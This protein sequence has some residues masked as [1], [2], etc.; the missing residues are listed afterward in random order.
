MLSLAFRANGAVMSIISKCLQSV[1]ST[2]EQV[3]G[4]GKDRVDEVVI[5]SVRV[6]EKVRQEKWIVPDGPESASSRPW[7]PPY[8]SGSGLKI[9]SAELL[10]DSLLNAQGQLLAIPSITGHYSFFVAYLGVRRRQL[11]ALQREVGKIS[12]YQSGGAGGWRD[13]NGKAGEDILP[14]WSWSLATDNAESGIAIPGREGPA[15]V[16]IDWE[17]G[18]L[19]IDR[20]LGCSVG[21]VARLGKFILAPVMRGN[22]F[23]MLCRMEGDSSW[24][25][26]QSTFNAD[27]VAPQLRRKPEQLACFAVPVVDESRM[28]AYWPCRGGYV[29]VKEGDSSGEHVW[30]FRPWETDAYPATALI[31]LGPPFRKTGSRPGYWQ[32]CEDHDPSK[33][34][35]L[36][37]KIIKLDGDE[38]VDSDISEYGQ[39]VTTGSACFTWLY[40]HWSDLHQFNPNQGEHN[41]LRYPLLQFGEKG[42]TLVAKVRP[43]SGREDMGLFNEVFFN[44]FEKSSVYIRFVIEG[45]GTPE[46]A[47]YAEDVEGCDGVQGSLF[48]L[49]LAQLPEVSVFIYDDRIHIYFPEQSKCYR[50]PL[51]MMEL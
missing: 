7:I 36:V 23:F 35:Y 44:P 8:G 5:Q 4:V 19:K 25:E 11:F 9:H 49:S 15:W 45:A 18:N 10:A 14:E 38:H 27:A 1:K 13:L 41:E 28:I 22:R 43:W 12:V 24:S 39:F 26:C 6:V 42:L 51:E 40:D 48:R 46:K 47:L 21:G 20:G 2:F 30:E 29:R 33:R 37:N 16:T 32:L 50:W 34:D 17:A 31:E 3:K